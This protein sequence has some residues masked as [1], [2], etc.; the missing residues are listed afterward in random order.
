MIDQHIRDCSMI[1][2]NI[3]EVGSKVL[4]FEKYQQLIWI[5]PGLNQP[6]IIHGMILLSISQANVLQESIL[7]A[8]NRNV[9]KFHVQIILKNACEAKL[10]QLL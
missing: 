9:R 4:N 5:F 3:S 10:T 8:A 7:W 6:D 1:Q 2:F